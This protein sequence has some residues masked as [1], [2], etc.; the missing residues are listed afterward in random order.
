MWEK[1]I[2]RHTQG[3]ENHQYVSNTLDSINIFD[4]TFP[5]LLV[6]IAIHALNDPFS[7]IW[8]L[9][10]RFF[11]VHSILLGFLWG[12]LDHFVY[13]HA[14]IRPNFADRFASSLSHR[15]RTNV[16]TIITN[17]RLPGLLGWRFYF[18]FNSRSF[19]VWVFLPK[20][21]NKIVSISNTSFV[22]KMIIER[23]K[24][25]QRAVYPA[26]ISSTQLFS[27]SP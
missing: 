16:G 7:L 23:K 22:S 20:L 18:W 10:V 9:R 19:F 4:Q 12:S 1:K 27:L 14:V 3:E 5:V 24:K 11:R 13:I 21:G 25:K 6:H 26:S 17:S 8:R 15:R 2:R